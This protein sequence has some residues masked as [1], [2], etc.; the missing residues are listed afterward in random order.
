MSSYQELLIDKYKNR[1]LLIDANLALLYL[2]G[3]YDLRLVGDGKYKKL[4]KYNA[5]DYRLLLGLKNVFK[6]SVTTPHV[7][8]EVSNLANDLPEKT[9][10]AC[11]KKFYET[12]AE[13]DEL[14]IPS[15]DAAQRP[16]F[17]FLGLTDSALA[18]VSGLFLIVTDDAR[19][20]QK[21]SESGLEALNFSHLRGHLLSA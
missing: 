2:V 17:H 13:I 16:D 4:S 1:G 18:L 9:K 21:M 3:S 10:S 14:T 15:M 11:L 7:L 12:F 19:L 8:T 6:K 5:E 20:V